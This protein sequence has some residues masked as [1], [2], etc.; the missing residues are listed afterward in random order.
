MRYVVMMAVALVCNRATARDNV[1]W[2]RFLDALA[3]VESTG[4]LYMVNR[5]EDAWG[6]YQQRRLARKDANDY[7]GTRYKKWHLVSR[8][9][10]NRMFMA[11]AHRYRDK[12]TTMEDLVNL[13]HL[14]P[15]WKNRHALDRGYL[16]RFRAAWAKR[17]P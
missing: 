2:V 10:A 14:G 1:H 7:I 4:G 6:W 5:K 17:R 15:N 3:E 8:P 11:Y 16:K 12:W 13:W 9:I